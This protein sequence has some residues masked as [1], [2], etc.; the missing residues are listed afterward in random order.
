MQLLDNQGFP[1]SSDSKESSCNKGDL[2]LIPGLGRS[3][4]G[5]HGNQY[6]CL[7]NP[8]GQRNLVGYSQQGRKESDTTE[9]LSMQHTIQPSNCVPEHLSQRS[10]NLGSRKIF[11][12]K[13][14]NIYSSFIPNSQRMETQ[15]PSMVES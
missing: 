1:G 9:R 11:T 6:S 3:S 12:Q 4:G 5:R 15:Y 7:E 8:H 14:V 10:V 2:G 13:N